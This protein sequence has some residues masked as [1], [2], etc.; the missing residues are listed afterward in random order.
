MRSFKIYLKKSSEFLTGVFCWFLEYLNCA[1]NFYLFPRLKIFLGLKGP[2]EIIN[3]S[4]Y[5]RYLRTTAKIFNFKIEVEN[6]SQVDLN[7]PYIFIANHSSW[8]DQPI[9]A[10]L[11]KCPAHFL[12]KQAYKEVPI[13]GLALELHQTIFVS[14]GT[15]NEIQKKSLDYLA[16]GHSLCLYPEGTR[17]QGKELLP[18]FK[19]GA[20]TFSAQSQVPILPVYIENTEKILVKSQALIE[21]RRGV[22]VKVR[23]GS[24]IQ[25]IPGQEE[26]IRTQVEQQYK[27]I[28]KLLN[29]G[30][31]DSNL[32]WL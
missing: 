27:K 29:K 5:K 19:K 21:V 22:N 23:I 18:S 10:T 28:N 9:L 3:G 16:Q 7:K 11:P 24:P 26:D 14:P 1:L 31:M 25:V 13:L 15:S 32:E 8:F 12:A 4:D 30:K 17:N 2:S 20:F 6:P